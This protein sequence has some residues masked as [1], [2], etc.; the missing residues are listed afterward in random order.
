M[1]NYEY[2]YKKTVFL[3]HHKPNRRV[4]IEIEITR[5][6]KGA[7]L[8]ICGNVWN[9]RKTDIIAGGQMEDSILSYLD[10]PKY[11]LPKLRRL[12]EIWKRYHLNNMHAGCEHQRAF[13]SKPYTENEGAICH[14]CN[15]VYGTAWNYE[16]LPEA[17]IEELKTF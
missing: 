6:E 13:E 2:E 4:E 14:I 10:Y 9:S 15:Y 16:A 1:Q 3:G 5:G 12:L 17:I 11:P 7:I 8:S